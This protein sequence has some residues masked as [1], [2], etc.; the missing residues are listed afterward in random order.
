[1]KDHE[2]LVYAFDAGPMFIALLV[3]NIW[4]PGRT[5]VT[6]RNTQKNFPLMQMQRY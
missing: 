2:W 3:M 6:T 5:L 1:M 4:H